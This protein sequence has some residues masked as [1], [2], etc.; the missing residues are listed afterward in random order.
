MIHLSSTEGIQLAR[1]CGSH[2][3]SFLP[4][5]ASSPRQSNPHLCATSAAAAARASERTSEQDR[6][7]SERDGS[8]GGC[9]ATSPPPVPPRAPSPG[10]PERPGAGVT[11][12]TAAGLRAPGEAP[13]RPLPELGSA[14]RRG[15]G[16]EGTRPRRARQGQ[17]RAGLHA[18]RRV[19]AS[20]G[21]EATFC[22]WRKSNRC[23]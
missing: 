11:R 1:V 14:R 17:G 18:P 6:G 19:P 12:A 4:S 2:A 20:A 5:S 13:A 8:L 3:C 21:S 22:P 7:A 23:R 9:R 10:S 15:E 16:E